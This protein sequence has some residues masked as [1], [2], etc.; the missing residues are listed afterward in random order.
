MEPVIQIEGLVKIFG[1]IKA[2]DDVSLTIQRGEIFGLLGPNGA[3]KTTTLEMLEGLQNPTMGHITVLGLDMPARSSEIKERIGVQLQS[4]A[5]FDFLT[6]RE[7]LNLFGNFYRRH[8]NADDLL[9][10]VSLQDK[11]GTLLKKLSGGQKQK[12]T[13]AASLVNDPDLIILDEPTAGLDPIARKSLWDLIR[14]IHDQ[15]KTI[16]LTTHYMEEA[17]ELCHRVAIMDQGKVLAVDSVT[18]LI[19]LLDDGYQLSME[20]S[21]PLDLESDLP[22]LQPNYKDNGFTISMRVKNPGQILPLIIGLAERQGVSVEHLTVTS[23][24]LEDVFLD[25]TGR[26]LTG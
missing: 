24:T 25:L 22:M 3:G 23:A 13:V 10:L 19:R 15:Q 11:A 6:L 21:G 16:V 17:E 8:V 7:I 26:H 2:V 1:N 18:N 20:T 14:K 5:Y 9:K 12:F 4:S